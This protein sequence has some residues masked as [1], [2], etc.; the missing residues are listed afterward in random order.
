MAPASAHRLD[1]SL[2]FAV[3]IRIGQNESSFSQ[4]ARSISGVRLQHAFSFIVADAILAGDEDHSGWT[5]IMQVASVVA[6]AG[7]DIHPRELQSAGNR[8]QRP[9][10]RLWE[11]EWWI[12][13]SSLTDISHRPRSA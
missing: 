4:Q 12:C 7:R 8:L 10:D 6:G 5:D 1:W 3:S 13:K 2:A 11:F 9:P